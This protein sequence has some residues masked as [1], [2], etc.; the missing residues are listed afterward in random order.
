MSEEIENTKK[1]P[2]RFIGKNRARKIKENNND[3]PISNI[4]DGV[5]IKGMY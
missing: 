1:Q 2:K 3:N 5:T 4:E